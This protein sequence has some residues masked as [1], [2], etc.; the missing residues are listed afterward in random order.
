M[1]QLHRRFLPATLA[2]L[3]ALSMVP[4]VAGRAA[5]DVP[6]VTNCT[7]NLRPTP[8]LSSASLVTMPAGTIVTVSGTVPGDSWSATC[9]TPVSGNTWYTITTVNGATVAS[10]FGVGTA[11]AASGLFQPST[12]PP[13]PPPAYLEGI[14][15]SHYQGTINWPAVATT[16]RR[17]VIMKVTEGQT[18]VDPVY[19]ANHV[20]VR[21][22]GLQV[23]AYH[24][25]DPSSAPNDAVLQADWFVN[26]AALL[27]GDL[28][29]A[30]DLE[31]TGGL[32]VAALQAWVGAWLGEVYA[33]L[34]VRPMIYT[35]PSFWTNS[36]GDTTMFADQG[37]AILWI[38]HWGTSS[39]TLPANNWGGHGWTFWQYSNCGAVL[40]ISG[41]V[42]LDRYNGTSLAPV[43][44]NYTYVPPPVVPV[45]TPL[46][47]PPVIAAVTPDTAPAGSGDT[48]LTVQGANFAPGVSSVL[49]NGSPLSTTVVS[50][51]QLSA[52][53][54]AALSAAPGPATVT[55]QNQPPGGGSSAPVVF[56]V[57]V[58]AAQLAVTSSASVIAWGQPVA[59]QVQIAQNGAS[60]T[61]TLQRM[62]QNETQW[63]DVATAITDAAG[64]ATFSYTPPVNTQFR[65]SYAGTPDLGA[66]A[67][68]PVRVVVRQLIVLRPTSSGQVKH[69]PAGTRVTFTATVRPIGPDMAP[70]KVT[71]QF[72]RQV[73]GRWTLATRRDVYAGADGRASWAWTFSSPGSWYVRA[74]AN[75]TPTNANSYATS[76][77]RYA[78]Y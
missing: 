52:V 4:L 46:N 65:A 3:L 55:V 61:V 31:Q 68:P 42:D 36:M 72:W 24:F 12:S 60:R 76:P 59:I 15:V 67:S 38:A 47:P 51:T 43:S 7:V 75:P 74:V 13:P 64:Q 35:S 22:A 33:K 54:P 69:V 77:E 37:Y 2:W 71:F 45:A 50:A 40:G 57:T 62:Q 14:D 78:V 39:P 28:V 70:V 10:L 34:G 5:A 11:Y 49:W 29:P 73:G 26:N 30:L 19:A 27:P 8:G 48:Q 18:Y 44:F 63:S 6:Y 32:S 21:A 23:A 9:G 66:G 1:H 17:F 41:C 25:A 58:P 16:G 20:A 56:T 53:V